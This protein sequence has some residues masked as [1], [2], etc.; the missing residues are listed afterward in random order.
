MLLTA[1]TCAIVATVQLTENLSFALQT[2]AMIVVVVFVTL[3]MIFSIT[4]VTTPK[5]ARLDTTLPPTV[6]LLTCIGAGWFIF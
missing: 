6:T 4:A 3:A 5:S 2:T 1:A